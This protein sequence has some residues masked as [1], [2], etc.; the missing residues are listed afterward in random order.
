MNTNNSINRETDEN[1]FT[2][3]PVLEERKVLVQVI[4][5]KGTEYLE[6]P[7]NEVELDDIVIFINP[8]ESILKF[9]DCRW[10]KV[11]GFGHMEGKEI[12]GLM[13][14]NT[15]DLNKDYEPKMIYVV[16]YLDPREKHNG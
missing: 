11:I 10:F 3:A 7:W 13:V 5:D 12:A 9:K 2:P 6:T 16:R 14:Y 15:L 4:K 8:D 1:P